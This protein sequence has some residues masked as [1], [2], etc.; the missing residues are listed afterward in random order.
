MKQSIESKLIQTMSVDAH[1]A[2]E[3]GLMSTCHLLH[4]ILQNNDRVILQETGQLNFATI[5]SV[6]Y[7]VYI[8][9]A[10]QTGD[11][12]KI[13]ANYHWDISNHLVIQVAIRSIVGKRQTTLLTGN[14]SYATYKTA[15]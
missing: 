11:T 3:Q 7:T 2:N 12:L 8:H 4:Q 6:G 15:A 14:F 13:E 5:S 10:A 9:G 1:I